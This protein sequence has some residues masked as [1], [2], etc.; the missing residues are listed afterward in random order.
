MKRIRQQEQAGNK[1]LIFLGILTVGGQHRRLSAS[2]RVSAKEDPAWNHL[3]DYLC[4]APQ[5]G[6]II[7]GAAGK[8]RPMGP[9]LAEW[10]ITTQ[11]RKAGI[12]KG[13]GNG[14]Q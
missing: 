6:A 8:R 11:D 9:E 5:S 2:I 12:G 13:A 4:R 14:N 1:L 10:E 7:G 3:L